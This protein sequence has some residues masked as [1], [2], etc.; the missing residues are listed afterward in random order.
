MRVLEFTPI[1]AEFVWR[2]CTICN[3]WWCK[4]VPGNTQTRPFFFLTSTRLLTFNPIFWCNRFFAFL[5]HFWG[6]WPSGPSRL[7]P[8]R[9]FMQNG[10]V[11]K[12]RALR[13]TCFVPFFAF[14]FDRQFLAN[15]FF[16]AAELAQCIFMHL[17]I[18]SVPLLDSARNLTCFGITMLSCRNHTSG[19]PG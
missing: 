5:A 7:D 11:E 3:I 2:F 6:L 16:Q 18:V 14:N 10:L 15:I 19:R 1:T 13:A 8:P 9:N 17:Q 12:F 4:N